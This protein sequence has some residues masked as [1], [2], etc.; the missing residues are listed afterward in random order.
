MGNRKFIKHVQ[1]LLVVHLLG[2]LFF[3]LFRIIL[4][5][6]EYSQLNDLPDKYTLLFKALWMGVRFDTVISGYIIFIPLIVLTITSTFRYER[7]YLNNIILFYL[8]ILYVLAFFICAADIPYFEQFLKRINSSIFNWTANAGFV[9]KMIIQEKRYLLYFILFLI[10]TVLFLVILLKI[11]R[12]FNKKS[13]ID[14][15][16]LSKYYYMSVNFLISLFFLGLCVLGIRGRIAQK[17]P[18]LVGTA[19]FSNYTFPNQLGLNPVFTLMN[20]VL[21]SSKEEN[22]TLHLMDSNTAIKNVEEYFDIKD[23]TGLYSPVT[24]LIKADSLPSRKNVVLILMES[25][26]ANYMQKFGQKKLLTPFLDSLSE[27]S[28]FFTN[29]YSA[30]IHTMNGLYAALYGYPSLLKQHPLRKVDVGNYNGIAGVLSEKGY[31]SFYFTTHDDQF[32]NVAGFLLSNGF[33]KIISQKDY[34][35]DKVLSTLGVPDDYMFDYSMPIL[36]GLSEQGKPFLSVFMTAYNH[37]PI[38]V[39]TYFKSK[40]VKTEDQIVDY[41]DWALRKF[42]NNCKKQ[43]WFKNTM[44]VFVADHGRIIGSNQFEMPLSYHHIPLIIYDGQREQ[45]PCKFNQMG[46]QIDVFPTI[47]GLLNESYTNTTLGIDLLKEKRPY[48]YFSAD[49]KIG[50]MDHNYFYIYHTDGREELYNMNNSGKENYLKQNSETAQKMKNYAFSM[51]QTSQWLI[52]Q[53]KTGIKK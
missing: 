21:D 8:A 30:G 52:L 47:M 22:K 26:S 31:Q 28:Y 25:M 6:S 38:I 32:D 45:K 43:K 44:F 11:N 41:S 48:I 13:E 20:D 24:R 19:F 10:I 1:F 4:L 23:T 29:I 35:S 12:I 3:M 50:C 9:F 5:F 49:D 2:I 18:I 16:G 14:T 27:Q 42:F 36:N 46:G 39:P 51:L 53:H 15:L 37:G 34:P 17:S 7:K 33:N 40:L